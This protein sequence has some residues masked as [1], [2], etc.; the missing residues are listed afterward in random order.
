MSD[1]PL[2]QLLYAV[3]LAS[4]EAGRAMA[5]RLGIGVSDT[6]ALQRL[7]THGPEGPVDLGRALGLGS[8]AATT[9]A[10]RL[11]RSGHVERRRQAGDR[12]RLQL[13]PT[14]RAA[15]DAWRVLGPLVALLDA[16]EAELDE[17][18]RAAVARYLTAVADAYRTY[19]T[20]SGT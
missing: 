9:L 7:L 8:A 14:E 16:V 17:Q 2:S 4:D 11:E 19:T 3:L 10:D 20:S 1:Q 13:V 15:Q 18:A 12:R 5:S 6:A